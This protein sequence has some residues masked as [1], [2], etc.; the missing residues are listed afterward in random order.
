MFLI[1]FWN[2]W[3]SK[4]WSSAFH[5]LTDRLFG[6][7]KDE[8]LIAVLTPND[9]AL[10]KVINKDTEFAEV[11]KALEEPIGSARL[12][13]IVK[14]GEKIAIITSDLTR[15]MPTWKVMPQLLDE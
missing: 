5:S 11:K 3:S 4:H 8:N 13:D 2:R 12:K 9:D 15:P 7:V 6:I 14:P 1:I 10:P